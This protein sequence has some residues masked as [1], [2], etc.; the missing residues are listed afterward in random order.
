MT[1]TAIADVGDTLI[2]LLKATSGIPADKIELFS[3]AEVEGQ[4]IRLT[5]FLYDILETPELKNQNRLLVSPTQSRAAPL[6]LNL[7]Y[8][9][10][11]HLPPGMA[12]G[13]T[14]QTLEAHRNLGRAMRVF[15]DNGILAGTVLRG[16]LAG[17]G[18]ELRLTLNP[19]SVEDMTRVW[20]LFPESNYRP[21]VAYLVTPASID[22]DRL[23][24]E[25]RV[26]ERRGDFDHV[27]PTRREA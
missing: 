18:A 15:Y 9:L 24:D 14:A 2:S 27:V 11:S 10:T 3:P 4:D 22:S 12:G 5:L 20:S 21:S 16:A 23:L 6:Y 19:M 8:L 13:P 17:T 1:V 25:Q 26:V 7:Y